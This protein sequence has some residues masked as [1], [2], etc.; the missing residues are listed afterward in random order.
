MLG[1]GPGTQ[2]HYRAYSVGNRERDGMA[3]IDHWV[4]VAGGWLNSDRPP[5]PVQYDDATKTWNVHGYDEAMTVLGDPVTFSSDT[6][7]IFP[8]ADEFAPGDLVRLDPP[9]HS[10][11]RKLINRAFTPRAIAGLEPRVV[12]LTGE[13]LD[14]VDNPRRLELI[15]DLAYPLPMIV[16]AEL[17]GVPPGDRAMFK[18]RVDAMFDSDQHL[19]ASSAA[20]QQRQLEESMLQVRHLTDYLGEHVEHRRRNPREDLITRLVEA[21]VDGER[22]SHT[23]VANFAVL[24]LI[25]GHVTTTMLIGNTVLCWDADPQHQ[26][27][28]RTD[29]STIPAMIEESLRLLSPFTSVGRV[30]TTDTELGEQQIPAD[31]LVMVW[32]G[33]ANRDPRQFS[34]P[35]VFDPTRDPN[36][37]L[38]FGRGIHFC[39]GAPL[40][41]MQGRVAL[42]QLLDRFPNLTV[43]PHQPPDFQPNPNMTGVRK[44]ALHTT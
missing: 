17:I 43:D 23:E 11:L 12:Q 34:R 32:L 21:E 36:P 28:A 15:N 31:Q 7:R 22:L 27:L 24:L 42:N 14:A 3:A 16:I 35:D 4:N 6:T 33:A 38:G 40:A 26:A 20:Q 18:R 44:L 41:R 1:W 19:S 5:A 29:R 2:S 8:H 25:A 9:Q 37:H 30:T 10:K 13:L 39:I